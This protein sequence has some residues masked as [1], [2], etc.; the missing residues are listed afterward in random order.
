MAPLHL[1]SFLLR[2]AMHKF[3]ISQGTVVTFSRIYVRFINT[4][5]EFLQDC[6]YQRLFKLVGF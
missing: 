6:V 1:Q 5:V 2:K 4:Y 3:C